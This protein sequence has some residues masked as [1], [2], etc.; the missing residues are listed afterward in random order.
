M[1]IYEY[2][3]NACDET[4]EHLARSMNER[5]PPA[6]PV[7]NAAKTERIVSVPAAP[8]A[9]ASVPLPQGGGCPCGDPAGPCNN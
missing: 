4:F 6:C 3:C 2:R 5:K 1:P 8:R 7:C 9:A